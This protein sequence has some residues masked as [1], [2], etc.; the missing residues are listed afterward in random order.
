MK[1]IM[2]F[3]L[4]ISI[5]FAVCPAALANETGGENITLT[6]L[7]DADRSQTKSIT[8]SYGSAKAVVVD[9]E[10]FFE[11]SDN[12]AL[13]ASPD[14][15]FMDFAGIYITAEKNDGTLTYALIGET[16]G[17]DKYSMLMSR[18]PYAIYTV[19]NMSFIDELLALIPNTAN[20]TFSDIQGHWAEETITKWKDKGIISGYPD[21]T[22]KPD[23]PVTRAELAKILTTAFDLEDMN[24]NKL[25]ENTYSDVDV[26]AWY[27]KYIQC[28]D[29]YMPLYML[30]VEKG[31]NLPYIENCE[32]GK[33]GFLPNTAALRVHVAEALVEIKKKRDNLTVELPDINTIQDT[34]THTFKDGDY[35]ELFPMHGQIPTNVRR[36]FE[37]TYL[38]NE[39]GIMKGDTGGYFLPYNKVT[40]AELMTMIDRMLGE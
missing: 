37:Y 39:L 11:I 23:N 15:S 33:N 40:R 17:V 2:S 28:A 32:Q 10:K 22:F 30:P 34:L 29:A 24:E 4:V 3:V 35:E 5:L 21:G 38:A 9:K 36:M 12:M 14:P 13:I 1:K 16:G 6:Q 25:T 31:A 20:V 18:M 8:M 26:N 27:W 7:L 19:D